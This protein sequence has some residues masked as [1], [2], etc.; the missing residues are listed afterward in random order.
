MKWRSLL[1][2]ILIYG[3]V[4]VSSTGCAGRQA[5]STDVPL[6]RVVLYRNGVGYFERAGEIRNDSLR[7][8][9]RREHV[10]DFLGTLAVIDSRGRA[11]SVSFPS[12]EPP[13][14][15][16]ED[17]GLVD[18]VLRFGG[19]NNHDLLVTYVIETPIWRPSYRVVLADGE[20]LLQG[21]AVVQNTSGEDWTDVRMSVTS[22][23]PLS[24][25]SDLGRPIVPRRPMV[26]D[27]GEVVAAPVFSETALR[28]RE[29]VEDEET[30][31]EEAEADNDE[32]YY[33]EMA[34][35]P[36][37]GAMPM[38]PPPPSPAA[39][40]RRARSS[41]NAAP[42][43][44]DLLQ[45]SLGGV[46]ATGTGGGSGGFVDQRAQTLDIGGLMSSVDSMA[47][48]AVHEGVTRYDVTDLV[49][50]PHDRS[51]MVAIINQRVPG[52]D[53]LLYRP[54]PAIPD[55]STYPMRVVRLR[56]DTGVLLERGPV[57]IYQT[58]ALLGQ[59]L[60]EPLPDG[61]TTSIPFAID[62]SVAVEISQASDQSTGRLV[63]INAGQITIEQFNQ[64]SSTFSIRNG[65]DRS[66]K[67]YLRH[68]RLTNWEIVDPPEGTEQ[69]EGAVLLPVT[70]EPN[71]DSELEIVE[72]TPTRRVVD[73]MS[74]LAAEAVALYL[75]GPA[76]DAA[77][78]PVLLVEAGSEH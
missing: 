15:D 7:F 78:G 1:A 32:G 52:E 56:N 68:P 60:L 63:K 37:G 18:V 24:F 44:D 75:E 11:Q 36:L 43:L 76:V 66:T 39:T 61:G 55:S 28:T 62:R 10:S 54:N 35:Q 45:G 16:E 50:V 9:V 67:L 31:L 38:E 29:D 64:R 26:T 22:G 70:L 27:R 71:Q 59:G 8:R 34:Q 40:P 20:A 14:E 12:L 57:A 19:S 2:F 41:A 77:A 46:D 21:W 5:V 74:E 42:S 25:R 47:V 3:A 30:A 73:L 58:D 53:A 4:G 23:A 49:T 65:L 72:R 17:D 13:A 51:T 33:G 69:V 6:Q 48:G